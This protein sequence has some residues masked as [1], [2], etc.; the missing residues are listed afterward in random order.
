M[1]ACWRT[2]DVLD[3]MNSHR[4]GMRFDRFTAEE[5]GLVVLERNFEEEALLQNLLMPRT[6]ESVRED[7]VE[8]ERNTMEEGD[9]GSPTAANNNGKEEKITEEGETEFHVFDGLNRAGE[10]VILTT[11]QMKKVFSLMIEE[12]PPE[13][14]G[15]E[16]EEEVEN[17]VRKVDWKMAVLNT[18][19][20]L[21]RN[22]GRGGS[23]EKVAESEGRES[24]STDEEEEGDM[25]GYDVSGISSLPN[26]TV[27]SFNGV[28]CDDWSP[29]RRIRSVVGSSNHKEEPEAKGIRRL[30]ISSGLDSSSTGHQVSTSSSA[31]DV[32]DIQT[33]WMTRGASNALYVDDAVMTMPDHEQVK[34]MP[35]EVFNG[36]KEFRA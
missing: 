17:A 22:K 29:V 24:W 36:I 13:K 18:N 15:E 8:V 30:N 20:C 31:M 9:E 6:V 16:V 33:S 27:S 19:R 1:F 32:S 3:V 21:A 14:T 11:E 4:S 26:L 10:K 25:S 12:V 23:C 35:D 34:G 28:S 2:K 5:A 7:L